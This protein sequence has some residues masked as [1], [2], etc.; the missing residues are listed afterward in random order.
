MDGWTEKGIEERK[1]G[2][3]KQL[4]DDIRKERWFNGWIKEREKQRDGWIMENK[5]EGGK[6]K[7]GW[8]DE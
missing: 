8:M 7:D 3:G 4:M 6:E 1:M 5:E 2:G